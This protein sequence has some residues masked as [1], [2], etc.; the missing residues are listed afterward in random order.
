MTSPGHR[1]DADPPDGTPTPAYPPVSPPAARR[2]TG[3]PGGGPRPPAD[4]AWPTPDNPWP[5][6]DDEAPA[7]QHRAAPGPGGRRALLAGGAVAVVA[8]LV[9]A[10]VLAS[11]VGGPAGPSSTLDGAAPAL[12]APPT[13]PAVPS[14]LPTVPPP[15]SARLGGPIPTVPAVGASAAGPASPAPGT[16]APR[17]SRRAGA[18]ATASVR[19]AVPPPPARPAVP[20]PL[21]VVARPGHGAIV[22]TWNPPR[23]AADASPIVRYDLTVVRLADGASETIMV[24]VVMP[25]NGIYQPV[26]GLA[27]GYAYAVTVT[28]IDQGG[29]RSAPASGGTV[30]P[31]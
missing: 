8:V 30:V 15:G 19:G 22:V 6:D 7:G 9:T 28:A 24:S 13:G 5:P 3:A 26:T 2:G 14:L 29:R 25:G 17:S 11:H 10:A 18:S 16:S 4:D 31:S 1:G 20:P 12:L 27:G 21:D 23:V